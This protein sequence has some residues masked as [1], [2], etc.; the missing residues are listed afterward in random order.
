M[1]QAF[2]VV[3]DKSLTGSHNDI[4]GITQQEK[5]EGRFFLITDVMVQHRF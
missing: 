1:S 4:E 2:R 5:T 3:K